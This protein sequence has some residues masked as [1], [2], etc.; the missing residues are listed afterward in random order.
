MAAPRGTR[1]TQLH[2]SP[3]V[4]MPCRG[5]ALRASHISPQV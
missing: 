5:D 1:T 4:L 3:C 2:P